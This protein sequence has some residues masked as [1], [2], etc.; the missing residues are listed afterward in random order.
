MAENAESRL[1]TWEAAVQWL[2]DQP[3][4]QALV[5][6]AYYDDP[7]IASCERYYRS[8]EWNAV[9]ALLAGRSGAALD[10]GA[11]RG[12]ASFALAKDGF[13]VTALEP[14]PSALVGAEAIRAM[15]DQ[16]KLSISVTEEFSETLP[17][18]DAS[19]DVVFARAV[20]HHTRDLTAAIREFARV[21]K[22]GG[23]FV[24]VREHVLSRD[25]DLPA[26]LAVHP[27]HSLYGGENAF[28]LDT[29]LKAIKDGGLDLTEL[30]RPLESAV[31]YAPLQAADVRAEMAERL[32]ALPGLRPLFRTTLSMPVVGAAVVRLA[33]RFDH[34]PGR[35]YSFVAIRR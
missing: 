17:F 31:N 22:P 14:D 32:P 25:E 18:I 12:I 3:D 19:F 20:L 6:D 28:R 10:V 16:S 33:E 7:L 5:H 27:L 35:H 23:L 4:R 34:R 11:G 29:Y 9:Q 8:N 2:R 13:A 30:L 1:K 26:F 24:A 15:A 21:L